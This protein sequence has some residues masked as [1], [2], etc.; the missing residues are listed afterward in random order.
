MNAKNEF[1]ICDKNMRLPLKKKTGK[2]FLFTYGKKIIIK[3]KK[4]TARNTGTNKFVLLLV[5]SSV[6]K[7]V[8]LYQR[9]VLSSVFVL[10]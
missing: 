2:T 5:K 8:N 4:I 7:T 1:C 9:L 3:N 10:N 6:A